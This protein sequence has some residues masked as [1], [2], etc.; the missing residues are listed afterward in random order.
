[1]CILVDTFQCRNTTEGNV[2]LTE[3]S[4]PENGDVCT[5]YSYKSDLF[6]NTVVTEWNLVCE[7]TS[8]SGF[9]KI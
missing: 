2:N 7:K 9:L 4:C 6:E 5:D 8:I 3:D 1:M